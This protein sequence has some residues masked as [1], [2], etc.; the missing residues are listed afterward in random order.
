MTLYPQRSRDSAAPGADCAAVVPS[1]NPAD[2][3]TVLAAA[4]Y[5]GATG[6][7]A[8]VT[9]NGVAVVWSS[10]PAGLIIPC[11]CRRVNAAGTTAGGLVAVF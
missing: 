4:I 8:L 10:C 3:F 9:E 1:D 6:D 11:R 5:V 2:D 7:V